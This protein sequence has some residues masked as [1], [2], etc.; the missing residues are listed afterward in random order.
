MK[1]RDRSTLDLF[2]SMKSNA[3]RAPIA[4]ERDA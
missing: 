1:L 4:V 3:D 2:D